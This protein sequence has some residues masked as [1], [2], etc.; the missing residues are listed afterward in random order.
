MQLYLSSYKLGSEP[1]KLKEL[2]DVTR[3][4]AV[5]S[6]A[7]DF[8]DEFE[9]KQNSIQREIDDFL[10]LGLQAEELDLRDYFERRDELEKKMGE[11]GLIWAIGGNSFI[12]RRAMRQSGLDELMKQYQS[13]D[14]Q[15]FVYAGYSAGAVVAAPT[16]RGIEL[17]DDPN[18]VPATYEP[19]VIW[20]GLGLVNYSIAPHYRSDHPESEAIEHVVKYFEENNMHFRALSDGE[21]IIVRDN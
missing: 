8:S 11:Y 9:R 21:V 6:S 19:E 15:G 10:A 14:R 3:K 17:V 12:L 4:V 5:I 18:V 7:L 2:V 1:Q 20:E 13:E 16:L